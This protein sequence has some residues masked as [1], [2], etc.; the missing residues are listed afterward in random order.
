MMPYEIAVRPTRSR[1]RRSLTSARSA[2]PPRMRSAGMR[3]SERKT[4]P[5][6]LERKPILWKGF[7]VVE[8]GV[9]ALAQERLGP[10]EAIVSDLGVHH[11]RVR[12]GRVGDE[13]LRAVE[14]PVIAVTDRRRAHV[15][16]RRRSRLRLGQ[17]PS[18]DLLEAEDGSGEAAL[19][20]RRSLGEDVPRA[21][22]E[23]RAVCERHA[24]ADPRHLDREDARHVELEHLLRRR[25]L[26]ELREVAAGAEPERRDHVTD[27]TEWSEALGF[28]LRHERFYLAL[29]I[30]ADRRADRLLGL[31]ESEVGHLSL[32]IGR[33]CLTQGPGQKRARGWYEKSR[34]ISSSPESLATRSGASR[35]SRAR[36]KSIATR[37]EGIGD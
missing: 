33:S 14:H 15:T 7:P 9:A 26:H 28:H 18:A 25:I 31:R 3:Q 20:L 16:N 21:Q 22:P 6:G 5:V 23:A 32:L 30:F 29:E 11:E 36:S 35:K 12:D 2:P 27:R 13:R 4:S 8:T 1:D 17:G 24:G 34:R 19:L 10:V 37:Q